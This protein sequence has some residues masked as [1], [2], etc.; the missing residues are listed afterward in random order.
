MNI[1]RRA[2][3]DWPLHVNADDPCHP[4]L[5]TRRL[6]LGLVAACGGGGFCGSEPLVVFTV[7][8]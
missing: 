3:R 6:W 7:S 8:L 4:F 1:F 2:Y 5:G